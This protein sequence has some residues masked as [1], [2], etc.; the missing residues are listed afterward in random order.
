MSSF[1][2][3]FN[4]TR[5]L[6]S[7]RDAACSAHSSLAAVRSVLYQS[8]WGPVCRKYRSPPPPRSE[9]HLVSMCP[10]FCS[11]Q[12]QQRLGKVCDVKTEV[13]FS[14]VL[15]LARVS[16]SEGFRINFG[17]NFSCS[18]SAC[19]GRSVEVTVSLCKN[20]FFFSFPRQ[21]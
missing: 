14:G 3:R 17:S 10:P 13:Y 2:L 12:R 5:S 21:T 6:C 8:P 7:D 16:Q 18:S 4:S 19:L 15:N 1:L 9:L 20:G 11:E